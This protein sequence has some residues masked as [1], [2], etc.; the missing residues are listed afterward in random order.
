MIFGFMRGKTA[1]A[2]ENPIREIREMLEGT[3]DLTI[4]RQ[5]REEAPDFRAVNVFNVLFGKLNRT[6]TAISRRVVALASLAPELFFF[7]KRFKTR[8]GEQEAK[9]NDISEAGTRISK[10]IEDISGNTG[11]LTQEFSTIKQDVES[12]LNLGN[13]SMAGFEDI[14]NQVAVLVDTIQVLK[15]NSASIGS[16]SDVI[17]G[18]SDETNILSLNARIEA[19]RGQADGKGFKVIAEEVGHLAKQSKEATKDIQ[20]RLSLLGDKIGETVTAVGQVEKNV[21]TCEQQILDAN[22]ALDHVCSQFGTLSNNLSEINEATERQTEDV[23]AVALNIRDIESSVKEQSSDV[24]TIFS[25]AEQVSMACD[26]MILDTGVFHLE[27]HRGSRRVAEN[28]A[29]DPAVKSGQRKD[30]ERA[31]LAYLEKYPLIELAYLTDSRG[32]QLTANVYASGLSGQEGLGQ[33]Y[34]RDWSEKEWF[35]IPAETH[36]VFVSKVYRSSAT[37]EFCFTVSVPLMEAGRLSGVLGIDV[38]FRD[39]LD[40]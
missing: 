3:W 34:G 5:V 37:R 13:R 11:M 29:E 33:G 22:T 25:I 27:G 32:K 4:E 16:I 26:Q 39:M 21:L 15:E 31:L 18:I 30:R 19:A 40:I 1:L 8:A 6:V 2:E 28:M 20:S 38:N 7:S 10:G 24:E 9:V 35:K 14:K 17:N 23:R 12:A 36:A